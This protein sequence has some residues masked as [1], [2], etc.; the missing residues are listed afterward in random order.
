MHHRAV[1]LCC[2][3]T[4]ALLLRSQTLSAFQSTTIRRWQDR[5]L[6]NTRN[7]QSFSDE[8]GASTHSPA[9]PSDD[10]QSDASSD[11]QTELA[12]ASPI[13][14]KDIYI[15]DLSAT[16]EAHRATNRASLIR[17]VHQ[18][19]EWEAPFVSPLANIEAECSPHEE[20]T[21]GS[22]VQA[23]PAAASLPEEV[24]TD[25]AHGTNHGRVK[26]SRH[27]TE[28]SWTSVYWP[29][30]SVQLA[31][32]TGKKY[33]AKPDEV[34]EYKACLLQCQGPFSTSNEKVQRPWLAFLTYS[35]RR[36]PVN[37][38]QRSVYHIV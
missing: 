33:H 35:S 21:I 29:A 23:T 25:S 9:P 15:H 22:D 7:L 26:V 10:G 34:L 6:S 13:D 17:R 20:A 8:N 2:R 37:S 14:T 31:E 1:C 27:E 3:S 38:H 4:R 19:A 28:K 11:W 24:V 16:L 30:D 36:Q 12:N 5:E 18:D 32:L